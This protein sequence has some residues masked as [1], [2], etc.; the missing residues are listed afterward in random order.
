[1]P[2]SA[3]QTAIYAH[4]NMCKGT[5]IRQVENMMPLAEKA[6]KCTE[7]MHHDELQQQIYNNKHTHTCLTA[8]FPGLPG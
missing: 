3:C 2:P 7:H 1:M 5:D 6:E 8:P 4:T